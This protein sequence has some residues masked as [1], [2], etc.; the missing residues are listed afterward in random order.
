MGYINVC[1]FFLN[2]R[3][4]KSFFLNYYSD[5]SVSFYLWSTERHFSFIKSDL[6]FARWTEQVH[7]FI[8]IDLQVYKVDTVGYLFMRLTNQTDQ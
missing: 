3:F 6:Y 5:Y 1:P 7:S 4:R 2:H 8:L